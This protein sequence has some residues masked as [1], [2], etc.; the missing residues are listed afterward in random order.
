[1]DDFTAAQLGAVT[2][3][4]VELCA[5][6]A[7]RHVIDAGDLRAIHDIMH[8]RLQSPGGDLRFAE[9]RELLGIWFSRAI[10][11]APDTLP[12]PPGGQHE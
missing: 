8:H 11:A 1:M 2:G 10:D 3:G 6:L 9:A 12:L 4:L 5:T 7:Q